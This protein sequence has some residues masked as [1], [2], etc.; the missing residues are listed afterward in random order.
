MQSELE[1][2][3]F[4]DEVEGWERS[5]RSARFAFQDLE[6]Y[7][8]YEQ[9]LQFPN[10]QIP[11]YHYLN[12][13]NSKNTHTTFTRGERIPQLLNT[14][15]DLNINQCHNQAQLFDRILLLSRYV[16]R[17]KPTTTLPTIP[18]DYPIQTTSNEEV[19]SQIRAL[20]ADLREIKA[21]QS[22]LKL[23]LSDIRESLVE[24]TS[25]ESAPKPIEAETARV[26][27]QLKSQIREV[28]TA[29]A[30]L[31]TIAKSLIPEA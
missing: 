29:L 13:E 9:V 25:R 15:Y 20:K 4:E 2:Q 17:K 22:S 21:V 1:S 24:I 23:S 3:Q 7:P 5:E 19:I 28:K 14:L 11:C 6:G 31:K 8:R 30:D 26:A 10:C 27:E 16:V 18:E 12:T